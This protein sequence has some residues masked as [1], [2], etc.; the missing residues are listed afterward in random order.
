MINEGKIHS[1][2]DI[3]QFIPKSIVATDLG[4]KVVRFSQLM[5]N[6]EQFTLQELFMLARFFELDEDTML[7]LVRTQ[8]AQKK[9]GDTKY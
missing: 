6:V 4:K 1:F 9:N 8:Y 3:F 5:E 2:K 7:R